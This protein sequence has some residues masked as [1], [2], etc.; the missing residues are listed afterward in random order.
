[1]VV[2]LQ[3]MVKSNMTL[4]FGQLS[5]VMKYGSVCP[6]SRPLLVVGSITLSNKG[7]VSQWWTLSLCC[8]RPVVHAGAVY[9][10][11]SKLAG[12]IKIQPSRQPG[13]ATSMIH[14]FE[15]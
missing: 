7:R 9:K 13:P 3:E 5:N 15:R 14:C 6:R 12:T 2:Y 10:A 4:I 1:M 8:Y 11:V